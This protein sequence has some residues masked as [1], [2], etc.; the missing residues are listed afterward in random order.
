MMLGN[1]AVAVAMEIWRAGGSLSDG[2]GQGVLL[3]GQISCLN[4]PWQGDT[5]VS[6]GPEA[7][8]EQVVVSHQWGPTNKAVWRVEETLVDRG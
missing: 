7:R 6:C 4:V 2:V 8:V 3:L 5:N 1:E